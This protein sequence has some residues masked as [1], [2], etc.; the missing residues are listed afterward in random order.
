MPVY[1]DSSNKTYYIKIYINGR[2]FTRR[3][4]Q[5][6][7][8]ARLAELSFIKDNESALK[9]KCKDK[10]ELTYRQLLDLYSKHIKAELKI[11]T[12]TK[13]QNQIKNYYYYLFPDII[14]SKLSYN[15]VIK[16]RKVIDKQRTSTDLKNVRR[17]FLLRFFRWC[18]VYYDYDFKSIEKMQPFKDYQI[19]RL[20]NKKA[21]MVQLSDFIAIYKGCDSDYY[22][23][24]FITFYLFGLRLGELLGLTPEAF[25]FDNNNFEIFQIVSYKV[26]NG[27]YALLPPKTRTSQRVYKMS[28]TYIKLISDHIEANKLKDDDFIFFHDNNKKRPI[29]ENT[30]R[31][32]A[33]SYCR[34]ISPDFHFHALRKSTV[35]ILHDQGISLEEIKT[36]VG[37][38]NISMTRD[39]YLQKSDEK[40]DAITEVMEE[41][42]NRLN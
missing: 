42:L 18:Y 10:E 8:E 23:L 16:A 2:Q 5:S 30:F 12:Y 41:V 37:H 39:V 34:A 15:D 11:T 20:K 13:Y 31:R 40:K 38:S 25:D 4:F 28:E 17:S 36:Y 33:N 1:S 24:A 9:K 21:D 27:S 19:K 14:L 7:K 6:K 26:N 35:T 32:K 29:A 3:G 22:R